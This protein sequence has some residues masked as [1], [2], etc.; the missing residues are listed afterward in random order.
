MINKLYYQLIIIFILISII[1]SKK[2]S[3]RIKSDE[4]FISKVDT[5]CV[6]FS[7]T[8]LYGSEFSFYLLD[9][10][11]YNIFIKNPDHKILD[12]NDLFIH[13]C[14]KMLTCSAKKEN[15]KGIHYIILVNTNLVYDGVYEYDKYDCL[16]SDDYWSILSG[17]GIV[18]IT[19]TTISVLI[20]TIL[21]C[22]I[23]LYIWI[24]ICICINQTKK[25]YIK[26]TN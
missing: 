17:F 6:K 15:L 19:I 21:I 2:T 8:S 7:V 10:T 25:P 14:I 13:A 5:N 9:K 24:C 16:T 20:V 12:N 18:G 23:C 26:R 11:T 4:F 3:I 22:C 1:L